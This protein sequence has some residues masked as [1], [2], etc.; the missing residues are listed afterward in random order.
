ML[1][2]MCAAVF[3]LLDR[4]MATFWVG[5]QCLTPLYLSLKRFISKVLNFILFFFNDVGL[6]KLLQAGIDKY[7]YICW[8]CSRSQPDALLGQ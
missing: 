3:Y 6:I 1:H 5:F 8:F 4:D 7:Y 2:V